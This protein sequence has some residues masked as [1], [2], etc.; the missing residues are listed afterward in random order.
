[1]WIELYRDYLHIILRLNVFFYAITG[2]IVAYHFANLGNP[3]ARVGLLFPALM[4]GMLAYGFYRAIPLIQPMQ[5]D[6][7]DI[8]DALGLQVAPDVGVLAWVLNVFA[9]LLT[10]VAVALT[11]LA[12]SPAFAPIARCMLQATEGSSQPPPSTASR[13][14]QSLTDDS[15]RPPP[16][17]E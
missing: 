4:S 9:R 7:F 1:M 10:V 6:V 14:T 11:L 17:P 12:V 8:R 15:P 2:A 5:K 3:W 16:S 13:S